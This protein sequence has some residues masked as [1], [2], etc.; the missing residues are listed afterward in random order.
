MKTRLRDIREYLKENGATQ[1][2]IDILMDSRDEI[3]VRMMVIG[4]KNPQFRDMHFEIPSRFVFIDRQKL[5]GH[6][7]VANG[8]RD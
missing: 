1:E 3:I 7:N 4:V 6:K 5:E 2:E 8:S